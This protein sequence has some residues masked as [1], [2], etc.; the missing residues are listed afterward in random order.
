MNIEDTLIKKIEYYILQG[1]SMNKSNP[2]PNQ[3]YFEGFKQ[4]LKQAIKM[5]DE[6]GEVHDK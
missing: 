4:G 1:D 3:D 5:I 6:H 2:A